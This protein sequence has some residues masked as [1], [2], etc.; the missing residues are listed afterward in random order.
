MNRI[1]ALL[2]IL[3]LLGCS[4]GCGGLLEDLF[5]EETQ[6]ETPTECPENYFSE[7]FEE[8]E[9][10]TFPNEYPWMYYADETGFIDVNVTD[11]DYVSGNK[12]IKVDMTRTL[13]YPALRAYGGCNRDDK[14]VYIRYYIKYLYEDSYIRTELYSGTY[15]IA[16]MS[17]ENG[18]VVDTVQTNSTDL[19]HTLYEAG[20][21]QPNTWYRFEVMLNYPQPQD[22]S[23]KIYE[24][25]SLIEL[26]GRID[27]GG[28]SADP[29]INTDV[30]LEGVVKF[31]YDSQYLRNNPDSD[32][33][34]FGFYIDDFAVSDD[35]SILKAGF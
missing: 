14:P 21:I 32:L 31:N 18:I 11:A 16:K 34:L 8:Y 19:W 27:Y 13:N 2:S 1:Y 7:D 10:G 4:S 3:V 9:L 20:S 35:P 28:L 6:D 17:M 5:T 24:G 22:Y 30:N 12:S 15:I 26:T 25:E 33:S 23:L 29:T